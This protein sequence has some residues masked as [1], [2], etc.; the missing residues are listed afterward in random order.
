VLSLECSSC[1][2]AY[3]EYESRGQ[4]KKDRYRSPITSDKGSDIFVVSRE[5]RSN[6]RALELDIVTIRLSDD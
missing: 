1:K 6:G 3:V 4:T 5:A 2:Q